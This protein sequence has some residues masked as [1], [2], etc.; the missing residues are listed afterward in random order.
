MTLALVSDLFPPGQNGVVPNPMSRHTGSVDLDFLDTFE[1]EVGAQSHGQ[2]VHRVSG[3][4]LR[5]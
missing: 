4:V 2:Q 3:E 1:G 5:T